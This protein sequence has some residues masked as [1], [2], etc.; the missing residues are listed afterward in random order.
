[1]GF[2]FAFPAAAQIETSGDC[3]PV[4]TDTSAGDVTI[5]LNCSF[6]G[7]SFDVRLVSAYL[8]C[9]N[10]Q[11]ND[12]INRQDNFTP[13]PEL[14]R[15]LQRLD[16]EFVYI[17]LFTY[18]GYGCGPREVEGDFDTRWGV[19]YPDDLHDPDKLY[20]DGFPGRPD[21]YDFAY[22]IESNELQDELAGS[23]RSTILLPNE[24]TAFLGARYGKA[25]SVEGLA[26]IRISWVQGFQFIEILPAIP[27]GTLADHYSRLRQH[28]RSL[29]EAP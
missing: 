2:L 21:A 14:F 28:V 19:V 27:V 15:A 17:D 7:G 1:M 3:S 25:F 10:L 29:R 6:V 22:V 26:K 4:V 13:A 23:R 12:V 8:A 11:Q 9:N 20:L 5:T 18:V 16:E 24:D